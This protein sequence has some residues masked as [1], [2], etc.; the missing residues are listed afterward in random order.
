MP[1]RGTFRNQNLLLGTLGPSFWVQN[2]MK[3]LFQKTQFRLDETNFFKNLAEPIFLTK[4]C[5]QGHRNV[6]FGARVVLG[7]CSELSRLG[8]HQ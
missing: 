4:W 7:R 5:P 1:S 2:L 8:A 6:L 3:V